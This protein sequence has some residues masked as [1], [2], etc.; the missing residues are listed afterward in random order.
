MSYLY[1]T[2]IA[3]PIINLMVML[4]NYFPIKDLGITIILLT[5]FIRLILLP[6]SYK[7]ARTQKELTKIQP[8]LKEIQQKYKDNREEQAKRLMELYK[9]HRINPLSGILPM[10]IQLIILIALYRS[11]MTLIKG[12][13]NLALYSFVQNPGT[14]NSMFLGL[15]DLTKAS[16]PLAIGAGILQFILSKMMMAK[17]KP[18]KK[19]APNQGSMANFGSAMGTQMTYVLP[20][21]T[22]LMGW[23]FPAGLPLYWMI[24]TLFSIGEQYWIKR[25]PTKQNPQPTQNST[26]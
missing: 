2:L 21:L 23:S 7:A 6:L 3:Q 10:I 17:N 18:A 25:H 16:A 22:I 12:T 15:V 1:H 13:E 9:T 24:T 14:V 19:Q 20:A 8:E 11:F 5:I 4:Y 26:S